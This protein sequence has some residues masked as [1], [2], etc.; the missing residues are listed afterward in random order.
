MGIAFA[1]MVISL[2]ICFLSA[3]LGWL[4]TVKSVISQY[5]PDVALRAE[6]RRKPRPSAVSVHGDIRSPAA[7]H[8]TVKVPNSHSSHTIW[9]RSQSCSSSNGPCEST[10]AL[11]KANVLFEP[12]LDFKGRHL[13]PVLGEVG[14]G[15]LGL[16][17]GGV[18][19]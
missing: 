11:L 14:E 8:L 13:S 10:A 17:K 19:E 15:R 7:R 3:F 9:P 1:S 16:G 6:H 2:F 18:L 5:A 12:V 4:S